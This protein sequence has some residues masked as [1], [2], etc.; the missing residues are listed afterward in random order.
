MT[1]SRAAR[2]KQCAELLAFDL[3]DDPELLLQLVEAFVWSR[4]QRALSFPASSCARQ[5]VRVHAVLMMDDHATIWI[6]DA[7]STRGT[8]V[9]GTRIRSAT[10]AELSPFVARPPARLAPQIEVALEEL[11]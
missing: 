4:R 3:L 11:E 6:Y 2:S 10:L 5:V 7:T 8:T 1:G 9:S